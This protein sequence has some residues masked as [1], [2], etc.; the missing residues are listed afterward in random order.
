A[1]VDQSYHAGVT[2][3]IT[4]SIIAIVLGL[5]ISFLIARHVSGPIISMSSA[6]KRISEGD[7][8]VRYTPVNR[9]DEIG[10]LSAS[11]TQM[12]DHM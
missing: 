12:T 1:E 5:A 10:D 3:N 9:Q 2:W 4:L 7:L 11:F 6:A 8:S